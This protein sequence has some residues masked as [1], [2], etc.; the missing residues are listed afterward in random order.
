V[1]EHIVQTNEYLLGLYIV[2]CVEVVIN[3]STIIACSG[4]V[5]APSADGAVVE[6]E[7]LILTVE[8][9]DMS[10]HDWHP[11]ALGEVVVVEHLQHILVPEVLAFSPSLLQQFLA[12]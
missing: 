1:S 12:G 2:G 5:F 8:F 10:L 7:V 3:P 11:P 4:H 6:G 9:L